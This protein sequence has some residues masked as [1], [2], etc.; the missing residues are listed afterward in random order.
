MAQK[1]DE[2]QL[3]KTNIWPFQFCVLEVLP[4]LFYKIDPLPSRRPNRVR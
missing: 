1:G 2:K 4:K 3:L